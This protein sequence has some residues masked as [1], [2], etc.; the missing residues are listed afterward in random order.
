MK[1]E[2]LTFERHKNRI[3]VLAF[4]PLLCCH[5][6][7]VS[8]SVWVK[9]FLEQLWLLSR[10]CYIILLSN[11]ISLKINPP[12]L[13]T[14]VKIAN[15]NAIFPLFLLIYE[16]THRRHCFHTIMLKSSSINESNQ[17]LCEFLN[18][19]K[20][21]CSCCDGVIIIFCKIRFHTLLGNN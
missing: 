21:I 11:H 12:P 4:P 5:C 13:R 14:N 7:N 1:M 6:R 15:N 18:N 19:P 16:H 3:F 20:R 2:L 9:I 8:R 10:K 17:Y